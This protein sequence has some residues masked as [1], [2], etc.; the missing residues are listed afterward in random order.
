VLCKVL[1]KAEVGLGGL[2]N[3]IVLEYNGSVSQIEFP[4]V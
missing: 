2:L 4:N 1:D 3:L